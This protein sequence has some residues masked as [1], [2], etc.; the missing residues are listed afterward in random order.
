[1]YCKYNMAS[2]FKFR[3]QSQNNIRAVVDLKPPPACKKSQKQYLEADFH[4]FGFVLLWLNCLAEREGKW[5][6]KLVMQTGC[7]SLTS[8]NNAATTDKMT[9]KRVKNRRFENKLKTLNNLPCS[10]LRRNIVT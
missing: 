1:M 2:I 8:T 4:C 6:L 10:L 7:K 9:V 3:L 5:G